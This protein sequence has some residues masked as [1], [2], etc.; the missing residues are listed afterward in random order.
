MKIFMKIF[1]KRI[2]FTVCLLA[3]VTLAQ[4]AY[5]VTVSG[6]RSQ[7]ITGF[8]AAAC[9]GAMCPFGTDTEPV[10]LL[11]GAESKIGLNI[12]RMEISPN[13]EGDVRV[14]EWGN[15]DTPYDWQGSVPSAKIVKQRGGI[16]FGTPGHLPVI[17]RPTA[18][19]RAVKANHRVTNVVNCV[20]IA[21]P[22]SF[23]G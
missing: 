5:T 13:F 19:H 4:A 17:T 11:Y 22:S 16:V 20:R 15:W 7:K 9:D 23:P 18:R 2:V 14:P 12:M 10:K 6:V 21:I 3:S 8:G 1:M